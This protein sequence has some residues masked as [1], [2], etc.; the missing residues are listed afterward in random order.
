MASGPEIE[1]QEKGVFA[2]VFTWLA[3]GFLLAALYVLS[4]G[5]VIKWWPK[6]GPPSILVN[7]Y[8]LLF[9]VYGRSRAFHGFVNWYVDSVWRIPTPPDRPAV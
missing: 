7:V 3:W 6:S 9:L 2:R 5:P 1:K 8:S 4:I